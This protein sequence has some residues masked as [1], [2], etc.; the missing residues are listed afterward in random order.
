M[1]IPGDVPEIAFVFQLD[2][3]VRLRRF[4]DCSETDGKFV[5]GRCT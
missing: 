5:S 4:L 3:L 1:I 2:L